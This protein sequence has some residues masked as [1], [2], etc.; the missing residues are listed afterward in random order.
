MIRTW[1]LEPTNSTIDS[2]LLTPAHS[3][4]ADSD[5]NDEGQKMQENEMRLARSHPGRRRGTGTT[6]E[7]PHERGLKMPKTVLVGI[8]MLVVLAGEDGSAA[9]LQEPQ[10]H[11]KRFLFLARLDSMLQV[12]AFRRSHLTAGKDQQACLHVFLHA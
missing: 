5:A 10:T 2:G 9:S 7:T 11:L 12:T 4:P 1:S 6:P 3:T 8:V